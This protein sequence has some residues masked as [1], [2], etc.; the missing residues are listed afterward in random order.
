MQ[1]GLMFFGSII[2]LRHFKWGATQTRS[3]G[4]MLS[5]F[6]CEKTD[7]GSLDAEPRTISVSSEAISAVMAKLGGVKQFDF[8]ACFLNVI[9][10]RNPQQPPRYQFV[11]FATI[12][13]VK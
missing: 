6:V 13:G 11:K 9:P 1:Q 8:F 12:P 5:I 2:G 10:S 7:D 3:A 4:E